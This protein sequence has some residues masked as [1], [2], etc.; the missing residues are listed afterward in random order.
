VHI[1]I[2]WLLDHP[3]AY[4][5]LCK[6]WASKDFINESKKGRQC[7]DSGGGH[8]YGQN[9]H[10]HLS[11]HM[12]RKRIM[13]IHAKYIYA[14]NLYSHERESRERPPDIKVWKNG[15]RGKDPKTPDQLCTLMAEARLVSC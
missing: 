7:R 12:V 1:S 2:I 6:L 10:I 4:R 5:A 14:T 8:T 11:K 3:E 13:K 15:H 9:G